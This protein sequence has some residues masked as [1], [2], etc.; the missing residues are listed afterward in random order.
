MSS[1]R[2]ITDIRPQHTG[3]RKSL[4]LFSQGIAHRKYTER[5]D[6]QG[7]VLS[8]P[9]EDMHRAITAATRK[10][11]RHLSHRSARARQRTAALAENRDRD[12]PSDPDARLGAS[13]ARLEARQSLTALAAATGGFALS[14]SN[15]FENAVRS[16]RS[17]E[18]H[19]LRAGLLI[20][21]RAP[22]RPQTAKLDVRVKRPGLVVR[23]RAG[24]MAPMRNERPPDPPKPSSTVSVAVAEARCAAW[25]P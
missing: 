16:D 4:L 20:D 14:N 8:L 15:S 10:Q 9:Q 25:C 3:R 11:R 13:F 22:R 2:D 12:R 6:Y 23:G 18:Q 1:F 7:G 21:Q 5:C 24:Y 19:L 17:G